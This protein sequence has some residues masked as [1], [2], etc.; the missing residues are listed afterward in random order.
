MT[1]YYD[2]S[3]DMICVRELYADTCDV[4]DT[5]N[6][7]FMSL[8]TILKTLMQNAGAEE[9]KKLVTF[10]CNTKIIFPMDFLHVAES[11]RD[12]LIDDITN[13]GFDKGIVEKLVIELM[14]VAH[15]PIQTQTF[16]DS[17]PRT[18]GTVL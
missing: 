3:K 16:I 2:Q 8:R 12:N 5:A 15:Q 11:R 18:N 17:D 7:F 6:S 13:L 14:M 1:A 4:N 10:M 9:E